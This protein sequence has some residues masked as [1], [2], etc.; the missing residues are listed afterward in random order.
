MHLTERM[1]ESAGV[2]DERGADWLAA[3]QRMAARMPGHLVDTELAAVA[4]YLAVERS[5]P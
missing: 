1:S 3:V 4:A 2:F 5:R